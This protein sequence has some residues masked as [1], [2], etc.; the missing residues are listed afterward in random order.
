[1]NKTKR[2]LTKVPFIPLVEVRS[3]S[4]IYKTDFIYI[5]NKFNQI[6]SDDPSTKQLNN[7]LV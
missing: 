7:E 5:K 4:L 3:K 2:T 6:T 1:M